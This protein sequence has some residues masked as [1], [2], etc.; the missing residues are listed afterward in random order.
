MNQYPQAKIKHDIGNT[1]EISN[2]IESRVSTFINDNIASGVVAIPVDNASDFTID[3]LDGTLLLLSSLGAENCEIVKSTTHTAQSFT[4]VAT[5]LPHSR[6]DSLSEIKYDKIIITKSA[7]IDGVYVQLGEYDLILNSQKTIVFDTTGLATDYYKIQWHNSLNG[8]SSDLSPAIS[9]SSFSQTSV[10]SIVYPVLKAM[11]VAENDPKINTEFLLGAVNDA[12]IY[13]DSKL[14]GIR[15]AWRQEFE[16]PV[17]VLAGTNYIDLPDDIDFKDTDRSILAARF[18]IDNVLSPFN[19]TYIPKRNWNQVTNSVAGSSTKTLTNIGAIKIA[20]DNVGDFIST[21]DGVAYVATSD[22]DQTIM[23]ITYTG[24]DLTTN[25]LTGVS[26][27]TRIIPIGTRVWSRPTI[28]QP[29]A[30]T[31]YEN[32]LYF[33]RIIPDSMQGKNVYLDYYKKLESVVSLSQELPEDYREIY[34]WYL[35]Y[36]IKYRK[37]ASLPTSDPDYKKFDE[38]VKA[39]FDNLYTGQDTI[40]IN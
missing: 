24:I 37:D 32:R 21:S 23:Q 1:I 30:Y 35:R 9:V 28:S 16:Y 19:L 13:T 15:H 25:E 3:A 22:Y 26:G 12:R 6:G 29:T 31:V 18:I 14:F 4:T 17:R 2:V 33:D 11:G 39:L 20:L 8:E 7:T 34:K 5:T 10:A 38:L 27:I 40:I 36:A